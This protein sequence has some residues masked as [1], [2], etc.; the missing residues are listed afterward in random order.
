MHSPDRHAHMHAQT[1]TDTH[2][3]NYTCMHKRSHSL[4]T[5]L[6]LI[7]VMILFFNIIE[8]LK[9]CAITIP[10]YLMTPYIM[11]ETSLVVVSKIVAN[12]VRQY[13]SLQSL[14]YIGLGSI[15]KI[16]KVHSNRDFTFLLFNCLKARCYFANCHVNI[17]KMFRNY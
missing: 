1:Y 8:T 13:F 17:S 10:Q 4:H 3:H 14:V 7:T 6:L 9:L 5:N 15:K 16:K 11:Q 2:M 12:L